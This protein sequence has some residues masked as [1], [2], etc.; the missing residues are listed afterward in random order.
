VLEWRM[1]AKWRILV[2]NPMKRSH[3]LRTCGLL[4]RLLVSVLIMVVLVPLAWLLTL[5]RAVWFA[6]LILRDAWQDWSFHMRRYP[7]C[8]YKLWQAIQFHTRLW[9]SDL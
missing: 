4:M 6:P 5:I 8:E 9:W 1:A 3:S 2:G 7:G